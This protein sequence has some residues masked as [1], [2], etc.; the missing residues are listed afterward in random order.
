MLSINKVDNQFIVSFRNIKKFNFQLTK[1][2]NEEL[3]HL[4]TI[5]NSIIVLDMA[6]I[7]FI[8]S[9][10]IDTLL[11]LHKTTKY[12]NSSIKLINVTEEAR[13]IFELVNLDKTFAI[14]S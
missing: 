1:I 2:I 8:D 12:Y 3:I 6:Q 11:N 5:P 10:G 14:E 13:E 4:S 9:A 7:I